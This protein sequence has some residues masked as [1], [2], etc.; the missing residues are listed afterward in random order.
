M[1]SRS[2]APLE[3]LTQ[4]GTPPSNNSVSAEHFEHLFI[5]ENLQGASGYG[6]SLFEPVLRPGDR[7][8][9][10]FLLSYYVNALQAILAIGDFRHS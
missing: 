7:R 2:G 9:G 5:R 3:H 4:I 8:E 6:Y 1:R 10:A